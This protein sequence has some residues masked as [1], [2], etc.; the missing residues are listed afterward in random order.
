[1]EFNCDG[2]Q[3]HQSQISRRLY[4]YIIEK[5]ELYSWNHSVGKGLQ[6]IFIW[7]LTVADLLQK[8]KILIVNNE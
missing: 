6:Y 8:Q 1:M 7:N 5:P 3:P 2:M 4:M